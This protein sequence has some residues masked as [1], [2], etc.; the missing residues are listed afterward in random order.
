MA[1][2][3]IQDTTLINIA[4]A[5]RNKTGKSDVL[6]VDNMVAE[7]AA[8]ETGV[9]L[10]FQVVGG[11]T[12]PA[13]PTENMIWVNTDE[14]TGYYFQS[15]QPE[16]MSDGDVW[17]VTSQNSLLS[18]NMLKDNTVMVYPLSVEQM[19]NNE[20]V[21]M[22]QC[23][24]IYHN[25]SWEN[26]DPHVYIIK[27]GV[28]ITDSE[29]GGMSSSIAS[30]DT[31]TSA[32]GKLTINF[33]YTQAG[34][35]ACLCTNNPINLE[36]VTTISIDIDSLT[37]GTWFLLV[38]ETRPTRTFGTESSFPATASISGAGTVNLD[39]STL[40]N[41]YY[42]GIGMYGQTWSGNAGAVMEMTDL[43]YKYEY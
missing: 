11:T 14:I 32:N 22:S 35:N 33:I 16:N 27:D 36:N 5:I 21:D 29:A 40:N 28:I 15:E 1:E 25:G 12:Q 43:K 7:I 37:N 17:F 18:F 6:S 42:I 39:V 19:I 8:I 13:N 10:N 26:F 4:D 3:L 20:L 9:K 34:T 2:Y 41:N 30:T 38:S 31:Y 23:T 24:E